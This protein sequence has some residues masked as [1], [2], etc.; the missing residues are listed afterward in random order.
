MIVDF[1]RQTC[2]CMTRHFKAMKHYAAR[3]LAW[4]CSIGRCLCAL[5]ALCAAAASAAG[6]WEAFAAPVFRHVA[7][8]AGFTP[9]VMRQDRSGM[10]WVGTHTGLVRWD[11]YEFLRD[12]GEL[13]SHERLRTAH[14]TCLHEDDEGRLWIGT[15]DQGLVRLDPRT[16]AVWSLAAGSDGLSG[17]QIASLAPDGRGGL[18][19]S[20]DQ[21]LNRVDMTTGQVRRTAQDGIP[22]GL[23]ENVDFEL[24]RDRRGHLWAATAYGLFVLRAGARFFE[25]VPLMAG[26]RPAEDI[27]DLLED[28]DG[29]LWIGT[30][31]AGVF[32]RDP[33]T[34]DVRRLLDGDHDGHPPLELTF[35]QMVDAGNGEIWL[36]TR[37]GLLRADRASL[38]AHRLAPVHAQSH[39]PAFSGAA[40]ILFRDRGGLIWVG[41][42]ETLASTSPP[43]RAVSTWQPD[44]DGGMASAVLVRQD[45][46]VWAALGPGG[47]RIISPDRRSIRRLPRQK[48]QP[49]D[50][51]LREEDILS[52]VEAPDGRVFIGTLNHVYAVAGDGERVE[53][54]EVPGM[55]AARASTMC[56][57]GGRLWIGGNSGLN[58]VE[59]AASRPTG[60]RVVHNHTV[61]WLACE[62]PDEL[63]V[64]TA[65]GLYRYRPG[66]DVLER[67]WPAPQPGG[68]GLPEGLIGAT[69]KDKHGRLWVSVYGGGVC[70]VDPRAIAG[71]QVRCLGRQDGIE[72][73]A[74]NAVALDVAGNAWV[75]T[76]NGLVR[77]DAD[78]D[79]VTPLRRADGVGLRTHVAG[80]V[81]ATPAGDLIFGGMGLSIV[82]PQAYR[83]PTAP[84]PLAL[85]AVSQGW[86]PSGAIRLGP[87]ERSI[88]VSFALLD[89]AAPEQVRYLYRLV[90]LEDGPTESPT[91]SRIAR[92]NNIPPGDYLFEV[93]ARGRSGEWTVQRWPLHVEPAWHETPAFRASVGIAVLLALWALLRVRTQWLVRRAAQLH[94]QVAERTRELE[95][96]TEQLEASRQELRELGAHNS[97]LLEEERRRVAREL[98]DELGQQLVAMRMELSVLRARADKGEAPAAAQWTALRERVDR[99]T[100]SMRHLVQ[101]LRPP[102]LDGGLQPALQ[103]LAAEYERAAGGR[104]SVEVDPGVREL[105]ANVKTMVFRVAQE[106]LNNVLRH[107]KASSVR[108]EL[109]HDDDGWDLRVC[110]D[111]AGFDMASPRRGFG[112]LSMQERAQLIGGTLHID[113]ALCKGTCVHLHL[114]ATGTC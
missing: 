52:M 98:H 113:S 28:S 4:L 72:D 18:W 105:D 45:G 101:N 31:S 39:A 49:R 73:N 10:I 108:L 55:P 56:V 91:A 59:L 57:T 77:I 104:C 102:A 23:P 30:L 85:T 65:L 16:G 69:A 29:R 92:Y 44:A 84:V 93:Q 22:L 7:V 60:R 82:H 19:I 110:D 87:S 70:R 11:G 32:V 100:A 63:L 15:S 26:D 58:Y 33:A 24:M 14:V 48:G 12:F 41:A 38:V 51:R 2:R 1:S 20:T 40:P 74:A 25:L 96:R 112:L 103:W 68:R 6:P 88:Q 9:T 80:V 83:P 53:R 42:I 75:S 36:S 34:G 8:P 3:R 78:M 111:G 54:L 99:L 90:G 47:L 37:D 50:A 71:E 62:S 95:Q 64:G 114:P 27:S 67:A 109:R 61:A 94:A 13:A 79:H 86:Q 21:G 97:L 46:S 76:D 43:Q 35:G 5:L 106:S 81:A 17:P 89:Y 66:A 107:A